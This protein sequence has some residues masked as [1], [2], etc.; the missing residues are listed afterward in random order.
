MKERVVSFPSLSGDVE[1]RGW[2]LG[3][4]PNG[5]RVDIPT[6]QIHVPKQQALLVLICEEWKKMKNGKAPGGH[7]LWQVFVVSLNTN[8]SHCEESKTPSSKTV[9]KKR[10]I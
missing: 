9:R 2:T 10:E 5:N 3:Y 4:G 1:E 7:K 6:P 8:Y